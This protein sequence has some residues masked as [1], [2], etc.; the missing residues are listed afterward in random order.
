MTYEEMLATMAERYEQTPQ[1]LEELM[2][3]IAFH[4]TGY[5]QRIQPDAK[6]ILD[7]GSV[8]QGRGLG[9]YLR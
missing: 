3:I 7:D 1:T 8:G 5:N 4:E 9:R 2:N 6:Q